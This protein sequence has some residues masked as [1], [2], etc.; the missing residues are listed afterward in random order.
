MVK[1]K[2]LRDICMPTTSH[3]FECAGLFDYLSKPLR[4]VL[5]LLFL[6]TGGRQ[7]T[8]SGA[9]AHSHVPGKRTTGTGSPGSDSR[10][11]VLAQRCDGFLAKVIRRLRSK[12]GGA[13]RGSPDS[14]LRWGTHH[15][16]GDGWDDF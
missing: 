5:V 13:A 9:C 12:L 4:C 11:A 7:G 1:K 3:C 15:G 6:L 8:G 14:F 16:D 2:P 10:P